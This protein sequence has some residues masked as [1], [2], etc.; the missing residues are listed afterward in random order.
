MSAKIWGVLILFILLVIFSL[1]NTHST[2]VK[3]LFWEANT[4]GAFLIF[5]TFILG[6]AIG[7]LLG[8][9]KKPK[10]KENKSLN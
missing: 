1:Q 5:T 3:F 2:T 7:W 10:I 9:L 8:T 4:S 6:L